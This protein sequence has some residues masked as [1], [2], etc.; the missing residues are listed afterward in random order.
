LPGAGQ[1]GGVSPV[2]TAIPSDYRTYGL[3]FAM[4]KSSRALKMVMEATAS[5]CTT[6]D[7][8]VQQIN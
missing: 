7:A 2:R 6:L 5:E 4:H 3:E 8:N 1:L